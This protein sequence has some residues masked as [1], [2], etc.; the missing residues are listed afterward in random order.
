VSVASNNPSN[1]A[2]VLAE[3]T[4]WCM[5]NGYGLSK[6]I[7]E[8]IM[9]AVSR[10]TRIRTRSIRLG[11]LIGDTRH[12][13]WTDTDAFPL[14]IRGAKTLGC[15]PDIGEYLEWLP[16]DIVDGAMLEV[17]GLFGDGIE[18]SEPEVVYNVC[19][20]LAKHVLWRDLFP[21]IRATGVQFNIVSP[22]EW[23]RILKNSDHD[24]V[25]NPIINLLN[26]FEKR[27]AGAGNKARAKFLTG[28][29]EKLSPTLK[30]IRPFNECEVVEKV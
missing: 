3:D 10:K 25:K 23:I 19:S 27:Y 15:L 13:I 30:N 28:Q 26:H 5:D 21:V 24:V 16:V 2:E 17:I 4:R 22:A 6:M 9:C 11:Q 1:V 7:G 14:I 8:Q 29:A 18:D 20:P 12:G